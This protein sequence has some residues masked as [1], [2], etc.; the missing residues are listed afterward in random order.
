MLPNLICHVQFGVN[1]QEAI[2]RM[3]L[4]SISQY[5]VTYNNQEYSK[6]IAMRCFV[7]P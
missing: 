7:L 5:E 4:N 1:S 6:K 3:T 2:L